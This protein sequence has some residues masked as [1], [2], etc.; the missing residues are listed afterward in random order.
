MIRAVV[1]VIGHVDHGKTALVKALTGTDTDRLPEEKKRGISIALGF[2]QLKAPGVAIDLIDMPGHER[3]V[4]T[5]ISGANG[6]DAVLVVVSAAEG[7]MPQTREHLEIAGLLGRIPAVIALTKYD[8]V[9]PETLGEE[10]ATLVESVGLEVTA[11]VQ[12][13]AVHGLGL[14]PL[15]SALLALACEPEPGLPAGQPWLPIDRAFSV[16]GHGPVVT[17]TLRGGA[18]AAGDQLELWPDRRAVR[19]RAVQM[20]GGKA[21]LAA[22]GRRVALNLR[23]VGLSDLARGM[24][25]AVPGS[26]APSEWLTIAL[27]TTVGAPSL[28][29]GAALRALVGTTECD[30]RLRLLDRDEATAGA[31]CIAQLRCAE[32]LAVPAGELVVLRLPAPANTVGGG[33]VIEPV[34]K[35]RKRHEPP[36]VAHLARLAE[37]PPSGR[38]AAEIA[39][40]G[41]AGSTLTELARLSA[42][43]PARVSDLVAASGAAVTRS[44]VVLRRGDL[45]RVETAL[46]QLLAEQPQGLSLQQLQQQ[47]PEASGP[48]VSEA[49]A[50]L[51]ARAA[52]VQ[53]AG[54]VIVPRTGEDQAR[55]QSEEALAR[56]IAD[57]LLLA[58]L[59]PPR[60]DELPSTPEDARAIRRLLRDGT[61]VKA[62]DSAKGK[63]ILF[64]RD[65]ILTAQRLLTPLLE[66]GQGLLAGEVST[67]LAISRKYTMPL[68][69]HLDSIGFTRRVGDRRVPGNAAKAQESI[70]A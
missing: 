47:V 28:K 50:S 31:R 14:D 39:F 6:I 32:P 15:R 58:G 16:P 66:R 69:E 20:R 36:A 65:A 27:R 1:G 38:I 25:L 17:G 67:A 46:V 44:G 21:A 45:E 63:E 43:A 49:I 11:M 23:D 60:P 29:N 52:V 70:T 68:L 61:L 51:A 2:A 4:R 42:L 37:L 22:P 62:V 48:L 10:V 59:T 18:I 30:V 7:I 3:F 26:V 41:P 8:L 56:R 34:V 55:V 57:S 54:L 12:T 24:A 33:R 19:V 13:S 64:H 9:R 53:R 40:K 35:R 5:M